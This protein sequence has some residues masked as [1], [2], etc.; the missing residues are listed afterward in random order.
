MR[1]SASQSDTNFQSGSFFTLRHSRFIWVVLILLAITF[2][3]RL[4]T[5]SYVPL[6]PEEAYYWM[7]SQH[8]SLSYFD[9]PPMVAWVIYLGTWLFSDTEIGVRIC[10]NLIATASIAL[11]YGY[12]RIWMGRRAAMGS[13]LALLILPFYLWT[14][15]IATMDSQL[16]FFWLVCLIGSSLAL[17]KDRWWGWYLA[18]LGFGGAI[19]SKYTGVFVGAGVLLA[20]MLYQPWRKHLR[21]PHPYLGALMGLCLFTPVILWNATHGWASFRFQFLDRSEIHPFL[22]WR[23]LISP[24]NFFGLQMV[25]VTP[26]FAIAA[27][28]LVAR[29]V[30]VRHI[31]RRPLPVFALCTALPMLAAMAW[32]SVTFD[33]HLDW[34]S[35]AYLSLFPLVCARSMSYWRL[36]IQQRSFL[37]PV[38]A[39]VSLIVCLG[40]NVL[41]PLYLLLITPAVGRPQVFGP[42][43]QLAMVVQ[44]YEVQLEGQTHREPLII[45]RGKYRLA[46]E[47]AF[48]RSLVEKPVSSSANTTSQ[49]LLGDMDGLGFPYWLDR[50]NCKG[51]DC[52][53]VTDKDDIADVVQSRFR[54]VQMIDDPALRNLPGGLVYHLAICKGFK[55]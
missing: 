35:P 40:F 14:G 55:G 10:G 45:G 53:Y 41:G 32:K 22:S 23:S 24:L 36:S 46:S 17:K 39:V 50:P 28:S 37:W 27:A 4:L 26:V 30:R 11:M 16:I 29:S 21:S 43:H 44:R 20:I 54:E 7:Y 31:L 33:V 19:L 34:T 13:A 42:W 5:I 1:L 52:I 51:R 6:M 9:H 12:S 3:L 49:W 15:F 48:Y 38:A 25:A 2:L 18:G 8:P 47:L